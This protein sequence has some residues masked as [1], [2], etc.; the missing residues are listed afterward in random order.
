M[1]QPLE[2]MGLVYLLVQRRN[3]HDRCVRMLASH[4]TVSVYVFD[5]MLR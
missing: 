2:E 4:E 5:K 1:A 3:L